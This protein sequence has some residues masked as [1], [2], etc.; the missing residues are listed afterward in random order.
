MNLAALFYGAR[1][2]GQDGVELKDGERS[3]WVVQKNRRRGHA[4]EMT[5]LS[6]RL[7]V[8]KMFWNVGG[9]YCEQRSENPSFSGAEQTNL[10]LSIAE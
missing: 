4:I 3:Q 10:A 6:E 8:Q 5:A 9:L 7:N 1:L 2:S